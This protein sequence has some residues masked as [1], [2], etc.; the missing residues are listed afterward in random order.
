MGPTATGKT[1]LALE[2][3]G[4]LP[5]GLIS[6]D[7][8]MVYR[9]LDIGT[10]K[11]SPDTLAQYP[12]RLIDIRDPWEQYSA[13]DFVTD[14]PHA[15][16]EISAAGR[17]PFLVGGTLLYFR[18]LT[19]GL[20]D[21][22][23]ADAALRSELDARAARE[24]WPALHAELAALDPVAAARIGVTDRQ[25]IQR[26]LE[27]RRLTGRPISAQQGRSPAAERGVFLKVG[28]VPRDRKLLAE[29]IDRRLR[30]MLERGFAG[31]VERL[32]AMPRVSA[33]CP[34]LRA[35][36]Y[37]Q[38]AEFL[39]GRCSRADAELRALAATRQLAKRQL[40]WLRREDCDLWLD[41]ESGSLLGDLERAV[42]A[43]LPRMQY[44]S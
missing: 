43:A 5:L 7:S 17:V 1:D 42:R 19:Q 22:P 36:G 13:G 35:V 37:R 9:H 41:M 33:D 27:V 40:T 4:R 29:R 6:V 10:G 38:I 28:L 31:E 21:L 18:S 25:R 3:A 23:A 8:A 15:I 20:S 2:L 44:P 39:G 12:H 16:S 32:L 26:A 11:P 30:G 24:G 34:A 14:A